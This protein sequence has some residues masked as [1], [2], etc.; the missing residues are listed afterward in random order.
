LQCTVHLWWC[1]SYP[2]SV[3]Q[4]CICSPLLLLCVVSVCGACY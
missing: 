1:G 2:E 3:H 4:P